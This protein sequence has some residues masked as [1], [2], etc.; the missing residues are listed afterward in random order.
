MNSSTIFNPQKERNSL[1]VNISEL[2]T[3]TGDTQLEFIV[4]P[5]FIGICIA[6]FAI[7][8]IRSKLGELVRELIA[9]GAS[10]PETALSL[11]E[12]GFENKRYLT[13]ELRKSSSFR[14]V[15]TAIKKEDAERAKL[16][17]ETEAEASNAQQTESESGAESREESNTA[18]SSFDAASLIAEDQ[19]HT[20]INV[21]EYKFYIRPENLERAETV[22]NNTGSTIFTAVITVVLALIV[23]ALSMWLIPNLIQMLENMLDLFKSNK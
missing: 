18:N 23:A 16:K 8:F 22:Y 19:K 11:E 12:L 6:A 2:F 17:A 1:T 10:S 7:V 15:V 5:I 21:S 13:Q 20:S 4:W 14:K 3:Y 9:R